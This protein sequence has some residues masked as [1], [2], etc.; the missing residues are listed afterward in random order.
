MRDWGGTVLAACLIALAGLLH[1]HT[2]PVVLLSAGAIAGAAMVAWDVWGKK[3]RSPKLARAL[4]DSALGGGGGGGGGAG[5]RG[6]GGG[7]GGESGALGGGG[8]GGGGAGAA[9]LPSIR[10]EAAR[11]GISEQEVAA[12]MGI[13]LDD[14]T[15][16]HGARG[17]RGGDGGGPHG[18]EGG[19]GGG[20]ESGLTSLRRQSVESVRQ[21]IR[22]AEAGGQL[23]R[24]D[25]SPAEQGEGEQ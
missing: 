25:A 11:L 6:G 15:V 13:D 4:H 10:A 16:R 23:I 24:D 1:D 22:V 12:K 5:P 8:G 20:G 17:G 21:A 19:Q 14:P 2:V 3:R 9:I 7:E 18:G